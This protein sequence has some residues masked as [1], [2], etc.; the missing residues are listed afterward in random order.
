VFHALD[1]LFELVE[2]VLEFRDP[3]RFHGRR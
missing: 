1:Q 3:A 2:R